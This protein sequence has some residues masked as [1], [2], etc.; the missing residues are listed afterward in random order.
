MLV[1]FEI[2]QRA[3]S[4]SH[5]EDVDNSSLAGDAKLLKFVG[6]TEITSNI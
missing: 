6:E 2:H 4:I 1:K 5:F 3:G